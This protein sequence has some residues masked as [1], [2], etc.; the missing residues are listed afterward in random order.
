[1]PRIHLYSFLLIFWLGGVSWAG[2]SDFELDPRLQ[3]ELFAQESMVVDP[4]AL[5]FD[6]SGRMFVVEMRD[7][8][9]GMGSEKKAGG[10]IR[11]LED[12]D[13]DGRADKST[14]FAKDLSFPTSITPWKGGVFVT[15]PPDIIYLKDGDGDGVADLREVYYTGFVRGVTDSNLNGLRWGL[16]N[17]I[18]GVNG[19]NGGTVKLQNGTVLPLENADFSFDPETRDFRKTYQTSGGYGLVFDDFGHSFVTYNINHIQQRIVPW[20]YLE[21][22]PGMF[23]VNGTRSISDHEEMARIYPISKP[24][25]RVNHPEQAGYFS[26]AG[27][28]GFIGY[29]IYPNDLVGSVTVGDVVGNLVHR[30]RLVPDGPIFKATRASSE[31]T[32]EFIASRDNACR[33]TGLEP[34]PDGALYLIDMQRDVIEHPDY[35]PEK[36]RNK[37]NLR[38]GENRG[39]IY[40]VWPKTGLPNQADN[41]ATS[42]NEKLVA[43]LRS[44]NPWQR[45]TAQRLLVERKAREATEAIQKI[46]FDD[47]YAPVRVQALWTLA[48]LNTLSAEVTLRALN[49]HNPGVR[50]NAVKLCERFAPANVPI[51]EALAKL[52]NDSSMMTRFQVALTLGEFEVGSVRETITSMIIE[53]RNDYWMRIAALSSLANPE[54]VFGGIVNA[55]QERADAGSAELIRELSDL[56]LARSPEPERAL[57]MILEHVDKLREPVLAVSA[58]NGI[59]LSLERKPFAVHSKEIMN[60]LDEAQKLDKEAFIA[61]WKVRKTL[62]FPE[63]EFERRALDAAIAKVQSSSTPEPQ[64]EKQLQLLAFGSY[65]K[66][67]RA[68]FSNLGAGTSAQLQGIALKVLG[69]F[70]D[71][72]LGKELIACW[73][74][75]APAIRP[76]AINLLLGHKQFHDALVSAVE[77]GE[78]KTGELNL[79]LEQRRTLL[80][81]STPDIEKRAARFITDEE[82]GNRKGVAEDLLKRMP[83]KGNADR[84]KAVFER[85]CAMCHRLGGLGNSVGP[86][87]ASVAHR[88]V[89]DIL[90]NIVDPNMA[91][92]PKYVTFQVETNDGEAATGILEEQNQDSV[93]LVQPLGIRQKIPRTK[94]TQ[95]R[96]TG[97]SLMPEG[98]ETGLKP[99]EL[100]DLIA[101][102]QTAKN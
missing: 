72:R 102:V 93:T 9:Y 32:R 87:L 97:N 96:S 73:G 42:S 70:R 88:S 24:E 51:R 31:M 71:E 100:R 64:K 69:G 81:E 11:L 91:I 90:S 62:G 22:F 80:R 89:E 85:T 36:I 2:V 41:L 19:G 45:Q 38:A 34:G 65:D 68:I 95:M 83:A 21:R 1:M 48:G 43:K 63:T 61:G 46:A 94:I 7:F 12:V 77:R 47:P 86:D 99:E 101:F 30:D 26:S 16:D 6:E 15:A 20:H 4:V 59:E 52:A 78:L 49:D 66:V 79:D 28:V 44:H 92:N 33:M 39:R 54:F 53:N 40:R 55:L 10:T 67:S 98:L 75:L 37:L 8:P 23:A 57:L 76:A 13:G 58:L 60:A 74:G 84:G 18:H 50:E 35:I 82:Y 5:C 17:R 25:T 56:A 29:D 3:M 14:V 27:G